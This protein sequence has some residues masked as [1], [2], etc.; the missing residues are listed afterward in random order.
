[1]AEKTR[2]ARMCD[3]RAP[4]VALR[5]SCA[6]FRGRA[7]SGKYA[8]LVSGT[9]L[10]ASCSERFCY[11]VAVARAFCSAAARSAERYSNAIC[12]CLWM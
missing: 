3:G 11:P 7:N 8:P 1:M 9:K 12:V 2:Y 6:G 4:E 10:T 5:G